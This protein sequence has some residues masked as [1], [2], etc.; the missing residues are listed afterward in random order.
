MEIVREQGFLLEEDLDDYEH[1]SYHWRANSQNNTCIERRK[2]RRSTLGISAYEINRSSPCGDRYIPK[3]AGK[4]SNI[5][6]HEISNIETPPIWFRRSHF[7]NDDD[8]EEQKREQINYIAYRGILKDAFFNNN[9]DKSQTN[10]NQCTM[11]STYF[12]DD[13]KNDEGEFNY[14]ILKFSKSK[15]NNENCKITDFSNPL[16]IKDF[17]L[18][19]LR[20]KNE[21]RITR[22]QAERVLNAPNIVDDYYLNL[23]DWSH[24]DVIAIALSDVA[25]TMDV[26]TKDTSRIEPKASDWQITSLSWMNQNDYLAIG[27]EN[28]DTEIWDAKT[29]KLF[30]R[31]N[32]HT[33]RVSSISWN[34]SIVSTGSQ[35]ASI[36]NHD[37]RIR[38]HIVSRYED[39]SSEVWGLKWSFDG[40]QLASGSNDNTL[41]IWDIK[42]ENRPKYVLTQHKSAVKAIAWWPIESNLLVSGGGMRDNTIKFW[43]TSTGR[44]ICGIKTDSQICSVVWSKNSYELVTSHGSERN[45]MMAWK[46]NPNKLDWPISQT[47]ELLGHEMRALHLALNP[48]GKTIVSASPD[49]TMRFWRV[50]SSKDEENFLTKFK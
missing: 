16:K 34:E 7:E 50:F 48:D 32:G 23:L 33:S 5:G 27:L 43:N 6:L 29:N 24:R 35:D 18:N 13:L 1:Q 22:I 41:W 42:M 36:I 31:L 40:T 19:K 38:N 47:A 2:P 25:Y 28:G 9:A 44:E 8:Y 10:E 17:K 3:R 39:H 37:I 49:E 14:K 45:E 26:I 4:D 46:Y 21:E 12:H 15:V 30:R 11:N 20:V